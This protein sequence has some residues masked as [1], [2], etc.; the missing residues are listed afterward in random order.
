ME[1]ALPTNT[2]AK[3]VL[4]LG[5]GRIT[6]ALVRGL[7]LAGD[8]RAIIVRDRH[9]EK[10]RALRRS[11]HVEVA[12]E[13]RSALERTEM[14]IVAVRPSS[15]REAI[16]EVRASQASLPQ[17]CISLA[18]GIPLRSLRRWLGTPA[19]WVRA[20]PSPVCR[21]RKGLTPV[22]FDRNATKQDRSDVR[23][24][25]A[26][27]GPVLDLPERQMDAITAAHSPTHGYHA[28]AALAAAVE[29]SGLDRHTALA[30]AAHALCDGIEY[31]RQSGI[32]LD[33]L[34]QEA[35]TPGGI[36][37]A[38]MAAMDKAKYASAVTNGIQAGIARAR[39]N[40]KE[41]AST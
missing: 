3:T 1:G 5:G 38:T 28:L 17:L 19:R 37:A 4:F 35:A 13:L 39:R 2:I 27:V 8:E 18:A 33:E 32:E 30:A 11:C 10:L 6:G 31:W 25:F 21:I 12:R 15:V 34:L 16:E 40:A 23:T 41:F 24:F 9:P 20:M 22:S 36:A 7:R 29:A 26:Q 14:L